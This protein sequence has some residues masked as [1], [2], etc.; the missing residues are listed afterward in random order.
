MTFEEKLELLENAI[1]NKIKDPELLNKLKRYRFSL[2][3]SVEPHQRLL[4]TELY[5]RYKREFK[6]Y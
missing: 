2:D 6:T 3:Y 5:E 4:F 1:D